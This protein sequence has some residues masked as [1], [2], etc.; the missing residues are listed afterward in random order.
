VV[1]PDDADLARRYGPINSVNDRSD[2]GLLFCLERKAADF[3]ITSDVGLRRRARRVRL[4]DRV[5][6]VGDALVWLRQTFEPAAVEVPYVVEYEAYAVDKSD[7]LFDGLR[8]DYPGFDNWYDE[9]CAREHG[10]CW[11]VDVCGALAGV[12]IRKE[13]TRSD[14]RVIKSAGERILKLC[15]FIMGSRLVERSS[16]S[17]C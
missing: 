16:A 14:A 17:S 1:Y 5:L 7:P 13:E 10:K 6:S 2:C 11:V 12:V 8:A 3:L 9:K 15:T 4:G